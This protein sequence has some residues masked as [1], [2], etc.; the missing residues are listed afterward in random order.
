MARSPDYFLEETLCASSASNPT[1]SFRL[2][3]EGR[4]AITAVAHVDYIFSV[5]R[6]SGCNRF[7]ELLGRMLLVKNVYVS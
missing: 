4:V 5:G 1:C 2:I 3:E 7:C 6:Q